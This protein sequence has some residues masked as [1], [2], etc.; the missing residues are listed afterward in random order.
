[1]LVG[2]VLAAGV[3]GGL[4]Y[5]A[6]THR[7]STR[8]LGLGQQTYALTERGQFTDRYSKAVAQLGDKD[9]LEVRLGAIYTLERLMAES[10]RD[11]PMILEILSA[12]VRE[13]TTSL[14]PVPE[15]VS[16]DVQAA[17]TVIGRRRPF[18]DERPVD[19][20][21]AVLTRADLSAAHFESAVFVYAHLERAFLRRVHLE[22]A[23]LGRAHLVGADLGGAHLEDAYFDEAQLRGADLGGAYLQDARFY[24][25]HLEDA[26]F[27]E[28]NLDGAFLDG[29][30]LE[31]ANLQ[32]A[33]LRTVRGLTQSQIDSAII[34]EKTQL[35]EG[36]LPRGESPPPT[37]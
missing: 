16:T 18:G 31:G 1:V 23:F 5:T 27:S 35:P 22:H 3:A 24:W 29:A 13:T 28:T 7:L 26:D 6:R 19:L 36:L 32:G 12:W 8:I 10:A 4:A 14:T 34:N 15:R 30:Y 25:A 20:R 2:A 9:D 33:D 17:L 37:G 21:R 11:Q